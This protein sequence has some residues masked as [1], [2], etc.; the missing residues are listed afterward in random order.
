MPWKLLKL[1]GVRLRVHPD[2][3]EHV[4]GV[5]IHHH[6]RSRAARRRQLGTDEIVTARSTGQGIRTAESLDA[7]RCLVSG[8]PI[9]AYSANR[10]LDE[11]V[12][13]LTVRARSADQK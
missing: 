12:G 11:V 4:R 8:N 10:I 13:R 5:E 2:E 6:V 1:G 7:V 9:R 3:H